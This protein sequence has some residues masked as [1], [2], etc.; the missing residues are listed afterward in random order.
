ME[1]WVDLE[2]RFGLLLV[3]MR[4][5]RVRPGRADMAGGADGVCRG[6]AVHVTHNGSG[7][8]VVCATLAKRGKLFLH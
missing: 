8:G 1:I 3:V 7:S 6:G 5:E 4:T 2:G